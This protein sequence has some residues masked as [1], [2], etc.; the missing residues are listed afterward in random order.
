M[1][2]AACCRR[3]SLPARILE[4]GVLTDTNAGRPAP[5]IPFVVAKKSPEIP[6]AKTPEN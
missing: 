1:A 6:T 4:S 3:I 2:F 5:Q